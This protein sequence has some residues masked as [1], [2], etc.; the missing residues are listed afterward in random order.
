MLFVDL[1]SGKRPDETNYNNYL[2]VHSLLH[3]RRCFHSLFLINQYCKRLEKKNEALKNEV[4][5]NSNTSKTAFLREG[6]G[7]HT[8][9]GSCSSL[10]Y[11]VSEEL[12]LLLS[13][14]CS[15]RSREEPSNFIFFN[16]FSQV[17]VFAFSYIV[18][19]CPQAQALPSQGT[20]L[21]LVFLLLA[22]LEDYKDYM[23][24]GCGLTR[25]FSAD[26][27]PFMFKIT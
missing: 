3:W 27:R 12:L 18:V 8:C 19:L 7:A 24:M 13:Q 15:L 14:N 11:S 17:L 26:F 9:F 1:K 5:L 4:S 6:T 22:V 10:S 21:P 16:W 25:G 23:V 20:L 2:S